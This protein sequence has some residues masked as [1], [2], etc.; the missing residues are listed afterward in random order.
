LFGSLV[1][2]RWSSLLLVAAAIFEL[3][4]ALAQPANA[5][6]QSRFAVDGLPLGGKVRTDSGVYKQYDCAASTQYRDLTYCK[7][8]KT[9]NKGG[10]RLTTTTSIIHSDDGTVA[11]VNQFVE[12][13]SFTQTDID[14][15]ITRLSTKFGEKARLLEAP[16]KPGFPR[17]V[18][19]TWGLR[20][21]RSTL[22]RVSCR[23]TKQR[24]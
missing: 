6:D 15:E 14:A 4:L 2:L 13:A 18:V 9:D 8:V 22:G 21:A 11:Y 19:A 1:G 10:S 7:R 5:V 17:A 23:P 20:Q 12:P 16:L 3:V 24:Q